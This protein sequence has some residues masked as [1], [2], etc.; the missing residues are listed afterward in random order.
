MMRKNLRDRFLRD[1]AQFTVT[2]ATRAQ[3]DGES[4]DIPAGTQVKVTLSERPFYALSLL[5]K[6]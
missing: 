5:L 4:I 6:S 1:Q 2:E 3:F